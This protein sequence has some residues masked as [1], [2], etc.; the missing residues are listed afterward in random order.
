[1]P[2]GPEIRRAADRLARVLVNQKLAAVELHLPQLTGLEERLRG[3]M[4]E[5]IA[6]H[7]K[8]MLIHFDIDLTLYSH[9]QLYG[10]WY[11]TRRGRPPNT[12]RQLRVALH[13][14]THSA[15]LFSATDIELL[16]SR[17]LT[18]HPFLSK[19]GPDILDPELTSTEIET[20]LTEP[21][22]SG[23]S[24]AALYLDQSFLAGVGNYLRSEILWAARVN[25]R[26]RP[27]QLEPAA[28]KRL[29]RETLV[30]S[31]RAYRQRGITV[32]RALYRSLKAGGLTYEQY[33]F[34]AYGRDGLPCQRCD[35][36]ITR[37]E[38]A[39]RSLFYCPSCQ[40]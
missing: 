29:A 35:S 18:T 2:E 24:L 20:R 1:M 28:I 16:N 9:N 36:P 11:V 15:L 25:P 17:A 4:V 3:S 7:G 19:L 6:P 12:R 34:Q 30:I 31:R 8:A 10:R 13:T 38:L 27:R 14:D 23:R 26:Q 22:F 21:A 40:P 32:P 5:R 33:R 39:G 37:A